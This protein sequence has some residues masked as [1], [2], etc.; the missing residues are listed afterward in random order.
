MNCRKSCCSYVI[1][2]LISNLLS[3]YLVDFEF[4]AVRLYRTVFQFTSEIKIFIC[5]KYLQRCHLLDHIPTPFNLQYYSVCAQNVCH[6]CACFD[7]CTMCTPLVSGCID[8]AK[9][10][11]GA[12]AIYCAD[13]TS[14]DV[15]DAQKRQL[16]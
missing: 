7:S 5:S 2:H 1:C 11:A 14:N 12:V 6:E 13:V 15:N 8:D 3:H 16:S 4:S 9:C 10:L